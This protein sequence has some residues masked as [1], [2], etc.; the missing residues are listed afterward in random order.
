M[1]TKHLTGPAAGAMKY[2]LLTALGTAGLHGSKSVQ[3]SAL[4]LMTL[5]TARY[6][7]RRDEV[8]IGQRELARLW[9]VDERTVIRELKRL[10][11]LELLDI[12]IPAARGRVASYRLDLEGVRK[13]TADHWREVGPDFEARMPAAMPT[14]KGAVVHVAFGTVPA[15]SDGDPWSRVRRRLHAE[16]SAL[17]ENWFAKLKLKSN[18]DGVVTLTAPSRFVARYLEAHLSGRLVTAL[19]AEFGRVDRVDYLV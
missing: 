11:A 7:W 1:L 2:D 15:E 18:A 5:L 6:N 12:K 10:R 16:D 9:G 4:R 13:F 14:P 3:V 19:R 8:A 17:F